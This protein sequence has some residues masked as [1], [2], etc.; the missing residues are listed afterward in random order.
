V[1]L[2]DK[3]AWTRPLRYD[4]ATRDDF[5][6]SLPGTTTPLLCEGSW[7]TWRPKSC[8][9][10]AQVLIHDGDRRVVCLDHLRERLGERWFQK[11]DMG[12]LAARGADGIWR[13]VGQG[14]DFDR[15]GYP[16]GPRA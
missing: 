5:L 7:E 10:L 2:P 9:H 12:C 15:D 3:P 1:S 14:Y 11:S 8:E 16:V 4:R 6:R 13:R